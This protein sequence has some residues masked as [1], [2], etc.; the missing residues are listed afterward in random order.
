MFINEKSGD[1]ICYT[2]NKQLHFRVPRS[3]NVIAPQRP[4]SRGKYSNYC[5]NA[6]SGSSLVAETTRSELSPAGVFSG[7]FR[8]TRTT[9]RVTDGHLLSYLARKHRSYHCT[10]KRQ[11]QSLHFKHFSRLLNG[12]C[13]GRKIIPFISISGY[14]VSELQDLHVRIFPFAN[15]VTTSLNM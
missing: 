6:D 5:S 2:C 13:N 10:I 8:V 11:G 14:L 4:V 12:F 3:R 1:L 15:Y 9:M 7:D